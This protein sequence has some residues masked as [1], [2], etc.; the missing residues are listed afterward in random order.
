MIEIIIPE[1]LVWILIGMWVGSLIVKMVLIY[2]TKMNDKATAKLLATLKR[3][4]DRLS[5]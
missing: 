2:V 1:I 5:P 3:V 4:N